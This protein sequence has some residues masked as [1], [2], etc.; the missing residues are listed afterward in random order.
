MNYRL[1][2]EL[3]PDQAYFRC[4]GTYRSKPI[5]WTVRLFTLYSYLQAHSP[6]VSQARQMMH[7]RLTDEGC[8]E[9]TVALNLEVINHA[10][11]VKTIMMIRQ[12]KGLGPGHHE[13]GEPVVYDV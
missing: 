1:L 10:A 5:E 9:V 12:W 2:E 4:S 3:R 8:G 11:I 7:T 6:E 13:W